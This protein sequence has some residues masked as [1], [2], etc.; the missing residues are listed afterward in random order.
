MTKT[1]I[2]DTLD[3]LPE[4]LTID[5]VIGHLI[6]I[7]KFRKECQILKTAESTQKKKLNKSWVN[8]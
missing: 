1:Q 4:E 2:M 5:Q 6:F 8:G 7:E 3:K